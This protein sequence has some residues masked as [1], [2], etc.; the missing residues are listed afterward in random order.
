VSE[1]VHVSRGRGEI[2]GDSPDRRVE[3]LSDDETLHATWSRFGPHRDGAALH[4]HRRHSDLFYVLEGELT[5]RLGIE[6]A[7]VVAPAGTLARVPPLVVHGFRNGSNAEVHYLNFHA[8]GQAF[9]DFMRA[10]RDGRRFSYDQHPPPQDGGR[11][12]ADA[13]IGGHEFVGER[14]GL[15]MTL[16]ADVEAIAVCEMWSDPGVSSPPRH[17]H[18]RH[19]ESFYVLEGAITIEAGGRELRAEPGDWIQVPPDMP[20]TIAF[21]EDGHAR[22][23]NL[24]TPSCGF[25][26]FVRALHD[27][28]ASAAARAGFDEV[29]A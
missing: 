18:R 8:P 23:L 16:L 15:R 4:V 10:L 29:P 1:P 2:V 6:D 24:H 17:L 20:H 5:V 25:G 19:V 7:V 28:G 12:A 3:I 27:A 21:R 26:G 11:P 9:A 13:S 22:F 14:P